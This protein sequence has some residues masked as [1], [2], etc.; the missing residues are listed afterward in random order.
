MV[1]YM[2]KIWDTYIN[3]CLGIGISKSKQKELN[4]YDTMQLCP[5][6]INFLIP[7]R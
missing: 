2:L 3:L 7:F 1:C 4:I 5:K 6:V